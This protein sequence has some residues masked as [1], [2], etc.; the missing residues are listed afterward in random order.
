MKRL[1]NVLIIL[2]FA[3]R[4]ILVCFQE[5]KT[6]VTWD[7]EGKQINLSIRFYNHL[8]DDE[9]ERSSFQTGIN[10]EASN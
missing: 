3:L 8:L 1:R 5:P 6:A 4:A 10:H 7:R 2:E 9:I